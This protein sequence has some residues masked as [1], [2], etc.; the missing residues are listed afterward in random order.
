VRGQI[1]LQT[2]M[3]KI[4]HREPRRRRLRSDRFVFRRTHFRDI[5]VKL[6]KL[7]SVQWLSDV[8]EDPLLSRFV[9][10]DAEHGVVKFNVGGKNGDVT[11]TGSTLQTDLTETYGVYTD[12][13]VSSPTLVIN[14]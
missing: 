7:A 8:T 13:E 10:V 9:E 3:F 1:D 5:T 4:C 12:L 6:S 11:Y 14:N 2:M